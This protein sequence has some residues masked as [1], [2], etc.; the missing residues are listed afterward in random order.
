MALKENI[1][2]RISSGCVVWCW[3]AKRIMTLRCGPRK[4]K[5]F[6]LYSDKRR[7]EGNKKSLVLHYLYYTLKRYTHSKSEKNS[8]KTT[9][10]TAMKIKNICCIFSLSFFEKRK[11]K[12]EKGLKRELHFCSKNSSKACFFLLLMHRNPPD[13]GEML[14]KKKL[15]E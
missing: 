13:V 4:K 10:Y 8:A 11:K 5:L 1:E 9:I 14:E 3:C 15:W 2:H 7:R 12:F 6:L